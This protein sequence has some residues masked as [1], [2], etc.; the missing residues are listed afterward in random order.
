MSSSTA[1]RLDA[2]LDQLSRA[3]PDVNAL[4]VIDGSGLVHSN[5]A[6]SGELA[7]V[8]VAMAMPLR[9]LLERTA[10]ELGCG[11]LR[12]TLVEGESAS[13]ALADVDGARSV[14]VIGAAG[15]SPGALRADS[16]W[17]ADRIRSSEAS[18]WT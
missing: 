12:T 10:A 4:L 11:E 8:A 18:S 16:V 14:V 9:E 2:Y 3:N 1:Q 6:A 5:Q 7:R 15:A 13:F 17:L